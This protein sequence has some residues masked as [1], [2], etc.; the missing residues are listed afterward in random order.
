MLPFLRFQSSAPCFLDPATAPQMTG[1]Q[2]VIQPGMLPAG[3][4]KYTITLITSKG[5]RSDTD[6]TTVRV[7]EQAAPTGRIRQACCCK[8][9]QPLQ[10]VL[11]PA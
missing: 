7:L 4:H 5:G 10:L 2:L 3:N 1:N 9:V 6:T 8:A 11:V